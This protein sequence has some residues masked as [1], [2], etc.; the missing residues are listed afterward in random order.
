M[1]QVGRA[2]ALKASFLE[3]RDCFE[4]SCLEFY[5]TQPHFTSRTLC[6]YHISMFV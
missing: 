3:K 6:T 2:R 4:L 1:S 5:L